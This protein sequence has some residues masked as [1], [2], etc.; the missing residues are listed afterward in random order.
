MKEST[1]SIIVG[2]TI[3]PSMIAF[4]DSS[5]FCRISSGVL[6]CAFNCEV[7]CVLF[8]AQLLQTGSEFAFFYGFYLAEDTDVQIA[9][10]AE[11]DTGRID[12]D[13]V[14]VRSDRRLPVSFA[15]TKTRALSR[16]R[17]PLRCRPS[18]N[19]DIASSLPVL[20]SFHAPTYL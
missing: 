15:A 16:R 5:A 2:G 18:L 9:Y 1:S 19:I 14:D 6:I 4:L 3:L 8:Q 12:R 20:E 11:E 17:L 10:G 13:L 7:N